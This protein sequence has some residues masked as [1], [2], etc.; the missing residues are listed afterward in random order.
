M[1]NTLT[2]Q[3]DWN[4]D[5]YLRI[6]GDRTLRRYSEL[7]QQQYEIPARDYGVFYAFSK[8][9]F[10]E[11]YEELIRRGL[12]R[13]GEKVESFGAGAYGTADGMRRLLDT[14]EG[15]NRQIAHECD[16][17]EVYAY[18]YDNHECHLDADGDQKAVELVV[19]IFGKRRAEKALQGK[20]IRPFYAIS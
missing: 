7:R 18:E 11:G 15:I 6:S 2:I 10:H 13:R 1:N 9:Q 8:E 12:I 20:R 5:G 17:L 16:P 14:I 19:K 3:Q 4:N